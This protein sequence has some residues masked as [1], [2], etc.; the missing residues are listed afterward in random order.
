[1]LTNLFSVSVVDLPEINAFGPNGTPPRTPSPESFAEIH[2][3]SGIQ[4][5]DDVPSKSVIISVVI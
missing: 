5:S 3:D 4:D 1:M 2:G